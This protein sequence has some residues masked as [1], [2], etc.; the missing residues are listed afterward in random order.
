MHA[1]MVDFFKF[2][3][4]LRRPTKRIVQLTTFTHFTATELV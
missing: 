2:A 1:L 3:M 4:K